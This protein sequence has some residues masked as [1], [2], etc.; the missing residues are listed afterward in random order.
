MEV[1]DNDKVHMSFESFFIYEF[2]T[3]KFYLRLKLVFTFNLSALQIVALFNTKIY[4]KG[5]PLSYF[6]VSYLH[7]Q[8]KER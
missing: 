1:T 3:L 7:Q 4:Y 6:F 8:H 5:A 2:D